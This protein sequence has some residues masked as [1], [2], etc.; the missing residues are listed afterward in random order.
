MKKLLTEVDIQKIIRQGLKEILIDD[1]TILTP[2]AK[3][4]IIRYKLEIKKFSHATIPSQTINSNTIRTIAVGSDHTGFRVKSEIISFL[5]SKGLDVI[6]LGTNSEQSSD[7]PD[8][9]YAVA[10]TVKSGLAQ[11]GIVIDATG[12]PSAIVA[13]KIK[14]IRAAVGYNEYAIKS[15]REHNDSNV[16]T[17]GA[18]IF[19]VEI[20]KY[21]ITIWLNTTF[22]GG[23]HQNRL[24]KI[25]NIEKMN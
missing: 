21:F 6:D 13:N 18:R 17:L 7:Y 12:N 14:G 9:A 16:L 3:D 10:S 19:D 24:D 8:F 15:S 25:S 5:K 4:L 2:S 22:E 11:R 20:I 23:R 1:N